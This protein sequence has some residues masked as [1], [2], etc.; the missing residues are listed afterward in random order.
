MLEEIST[1]P[2]TKMNIKT[3]ITWRSG[4]LSLECV[5]INGIEELITI[6]K[7]FNIARRP[8]KLN[9]GYYIVVYFKTKKGIAFDMIK[10]RRYDHTELDGYMCF[11]K[12]RP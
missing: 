8:N 9:G 6:F 1:R 12:Y 3:L 11:I 7:D 10:V 2:S 5:D 4:P